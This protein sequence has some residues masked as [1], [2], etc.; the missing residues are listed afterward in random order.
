MFSASWRCIIEAGGEVE[1]ILVSHLRVME[2]KT[3]NWMFDQAKQVLYMRSLYYSVVL[4]Q[5]LSRKEKLLVFKWLYNSS[6]M[7]KEVRSLIQA[8]ENTIFAKNQKSYNV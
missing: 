2:G 7:T 3:K 1:S 5:E 8:S 4:S 6:A